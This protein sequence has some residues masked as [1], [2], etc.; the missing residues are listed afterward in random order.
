MSLL[1]WFERGIVYAEKSLAMRKKFGDLWGQGQSLHFYGIVLYAASRYKDCLVRC[2]DAVRLLERTGD[3]WEVNIARFQI[4]ASLYRLGDLAG[5]VAEAQR[6]HQSGLDL[7]DAQASGIS[8]DVWAR[9]SLGRLPEGIIQVEMARST[10]DVQRHAQVLLAE[11]VR[12]FYAGRFRDAAHVLTQAH[13]QIAQAGIKNAWVAP[14]LPWLTT[15]RRKV[16][17]ETSARSPRRR[18]RLIRHALICARQAMRLTRKF[19]NDL[20]HALREY[21]LV[22]ALLDRPRRARRYL[23]KSLSLADAPGRRI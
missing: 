13:Q 22:L 4:A 8:L 6:M 21:A 5:A 23:D 20:P 17:E 19:Q 9:A 14:V 18:R 12:L 11:G 2:R 15:A 3:Y 10:G 1:A 16:A 7:G